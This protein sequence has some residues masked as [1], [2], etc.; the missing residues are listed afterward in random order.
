MKN[1]W[2]TSFGTGCFAFLLTACSGGTSNEKVGDTIENVVPVPAPDNSSA[3]N[4]SM[5]D[6]AFN[7]KDSIGQKKADS[8]K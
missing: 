7:K 4:P 3:T 2:K 8:T 5:A 6:T 1:F